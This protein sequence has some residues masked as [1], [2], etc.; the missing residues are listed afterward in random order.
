MATEQK[1]GR[2]RPRNPENANK[3]RKPKKEASGRK[4][5]VVPKEL[6]DNFIAS[7]P[8]E[9]QGFHE[10]KDAAFRRVD[11]IAQAADEREER[12]P[13]LAIFEEAGFVQTV[14]EKKVNRN[15]APSRTI[16]RTP[17]EETTTSKEETVTGE[18]A[19]QA[20]S[21]TNE[22]TESDAQP[23]TTGHSRSRRR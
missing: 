4:Y 8:Q 7:L 11:A 3:P 21:T 9:Y 14:V 13:D 12:A 17:K 2:G 19:E 15:F 6:Y 10:S 16:N 23:E 18:N 22:S 5:A 1:K 20:A